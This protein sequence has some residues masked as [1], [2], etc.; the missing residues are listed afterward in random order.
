L[1]KSEVTSIS[2]IAEAVDE[3]EI[4]EVASNRELEEQ[5]GVGG[6]GTKGEKP[7]TD[8]EV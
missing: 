6:G 2:R 1:R 5:E 3:G 8:E 7:V 4:E